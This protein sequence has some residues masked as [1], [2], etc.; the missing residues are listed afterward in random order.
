MKKEREEN[1][2][3][4][5]ETKSYG[6]IVANG[7]MKFEVKLILCLINEAWN[8]ENRREV[9]VKLHHSWPRQ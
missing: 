6:T 1:V 3:K 7:V 4:T 9:E 8:H 2:D 5:R